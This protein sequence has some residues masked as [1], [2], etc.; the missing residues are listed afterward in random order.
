MDGQRVGRDRT[1]PGADTAAVERGATNTTVTTRAEPVAFIWAKTAA[2]SRG[3]PVK[4]GTRRRGVPVGG[5]AD[6]VGRRR[7]FGGQAG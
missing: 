6:G 5:S 2:G 7:R 1:A 3:V 4:F